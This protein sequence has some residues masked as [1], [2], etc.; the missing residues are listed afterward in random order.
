MVE[1]LKYPWLVSIQIKGK[2]VCTGVLYNPTTVITA[3]HCSINLKNGRR[4]NPAAAVLVAGV[5]DLSRL[6]KALYFN[7]SKVIEHPDFDQEFFDHDIAIWKVQLSKGDKSK[8]PTQNIILDSESYERPSK[9]T[10]AGW[11]EID[12]SEDKTP[13]AAHEATVYQ[14]SDKN[15]ISQLEGDFNSDIICTAD[16]QT[17]VAAG[18]AGG[19]LFVTKPNGDI[20]LV[21]IVSYGFGIG[22]GFQPSVYTKVSKHRKWIFENSLDKW[23]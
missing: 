15:C 23:L 20:W 4:Y 12:I 16:Y 7:V 8:L 5:Q 2:S 21:G 13:D 14:V 18:D 10:V 22:D 9:F 1:S 11:G 19:P 17:D 3:A 6:E